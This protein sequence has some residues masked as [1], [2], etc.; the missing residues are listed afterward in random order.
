VQRSEGDPVP[1]DDGLPVALD[2]AECRRL[3]ATVAV[4]R[5]GFTDGAL[6]AILPVPFAVHEGHVVIPAR[7]GS[8]VVAAV[9]GA[10]SLSR[11]TASTI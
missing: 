3:L 2:D 6:P 10:V 8:S 9:R 1:T 4:G 11:S 7:A 5:L